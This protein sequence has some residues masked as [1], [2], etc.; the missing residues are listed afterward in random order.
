MTGARRA[1]A[2]AVAELLTSDADSGAV[3]ASAELAGGAAVLFIGGDGAVARLS[4]SFAMTVGARTNIIKHQ[5][6]LASQ[7]LA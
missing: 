5:R 4:C 6:H 1:T 2:S 7:K 3:G